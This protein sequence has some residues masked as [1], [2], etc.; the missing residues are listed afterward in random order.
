MFFHFKCKGDVM[1]NLAE[2]TLEVVELLNTESYL[3]DRGMWD[4]WL[5][6]F[7]QDC[8]YWLP[9][10]ESDTKLV[11]NP[12]KEISLIYYSDRTGLEDRVFRLRTGSVSSATPM[13][14]TVHLTSGVRILAALGPTVEVAASWACH[15]AWRKEFNTYAGQYEY[16]LERVDGALKIKRKKI[17]LINDLIPRVLDFYHI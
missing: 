8:E 2:L 13:P 16:T 9:A 10:W 7:S 14:R 3:V 5:D 6:L 1:E 17:V 12:Q 4:E 15:W 11:T